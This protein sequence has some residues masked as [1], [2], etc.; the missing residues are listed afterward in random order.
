MY[1]ICNHTKIYFH[2]SISEK[3]ERQS[4]ASQSYSSLLDKPSDRQNVIYEQVNKHLT[5]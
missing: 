1:K 2:K 5:T 4:E 3:L